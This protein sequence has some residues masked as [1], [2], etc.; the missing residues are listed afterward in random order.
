MTT[1]GLQTNLMLRFEAV[2][3]L[4]SD[5]RIGQFL[6]TVDTLGEDDKGRSLWDIEDE[7]LAKALER[8]E[9][10]LST[11]WTP[12][13]R[14]DPVAPRQRP[15]RNTLTARLTDAYRRCTGQSPLLQEVNCICSD[16][17]IANWARG[18]EARPT[19]SGF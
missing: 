19:E 7:E 5:M 11:E 18:T 15:R 12:D 17:G 6:A 8:F 10:D 9:S 1:V 14:V 3:R 4:C 2:R 13:T 16:S